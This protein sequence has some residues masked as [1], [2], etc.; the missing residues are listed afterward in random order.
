VRSVRAS[1]LLLLFVTSFARCWADTHGLLESSSWD[2]CEP[3]NHEC[4][5][6]HED[7]FDNDQR[8]EHDHEPQP[9][10]SSDCSGCSMVKAGFTSVTADL[11]FTA[12][13]F[14][15]IVP[16]W[17]D[18]DVR[19]RRILSRAQNAQEPPPPWSVGQVIMTMSDIVT[20]SAVSVRGPNLV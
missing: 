5:D 18:L 12:P 2:C 7:D 9:F 19:I 15:S 4:H 14:T 3:V 16:E 11:G 17:D 1:F 8:E 10:P 6:H 13:V 20:T